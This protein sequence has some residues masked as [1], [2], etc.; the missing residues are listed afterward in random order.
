MVRL[1]RLCT[2]GI[3]RASVCPSAVSGLPSKHNDAN[4]QTN[5]L[6]I[7]SRRLWLK[8]HRPVLN[9]IT[10]MP[11]S[12]KS[13]VLLTLSSL[14][15][16]AL[17]IASRLILIPY[18]VHLLVLVTCILYTAA[19]LSLPLR[20]E[21]ALA[22]GEIDPTAA[23]TE[24]TNADNDNANATPITSETL[25]REDAMKMP[26]IGSF[27][28]FSLYLAFKFFDKETVNF[29]ISFYF[30]L[31]GCLAVT[32]TGSSLLSSPYLRIVGG[33]LSRVSFRKEIKVRH[34]LPTF[35]GG[36]S[37]WDL[38]VDF[39]L[40]DLLSFIGSAIFTAFYLMKKR[41]WM[42]NIIGICF[43]LM[44]IQQFSLG[45][46]KIG[47][48]ML[49]GLFFYDIFWVYVVLDLF[50]NY[51][52][53]L[54]FFLTSHSFPCSRFGT[55]VM[56]TVAKNLDGPIKILFPRSLI[57]NPVTQKIETSLLG[58]GDIIIPG[59]FLALLLRFDAHNAK[60][61]YFPIN[62]YE[63]FPKPYFHSALIG[64]IFGMG[65]TMFVMIYFG[66]AQPALLYLV[67]AILISSFV[68][69]MFRG[70]VKELLAY[71]EETEEED[72]KDKDKDTATN[73]K[74]Q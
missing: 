3:W 8:C 54:F 34:G 26:I 21:Q 63:S 5:L 12:S 37:P 46:Y 44:G 67:P 11:E 47:A 23:L 25:R 50:L 20:Q 10:R 35:I 58:L 66:A 4:K 68:T 65:L 43:C 48:V 17:S 9:N 61:P 55:N 13:N 19:H 42:N 74:D 70:E 72:K 14:T 33:P 24:S 18:V 29:I 49:I 60:V 73:K 32:A 16:V 39:N 69:A 31:V 64:Y 62:I 71:S 57:P 15:I 36:E 38:S 7:K 1:V 56:V 59:F 40:A 51:W 41:W 22:R 53:L 27:A 30:G 52:S 2:Y 28:L 6:T 45:T